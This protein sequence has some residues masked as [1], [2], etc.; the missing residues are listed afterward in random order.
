[1]LVYYLCTQPM[2]KSKSSAVGGP[3]V[4]KR[5]KSFLPWNRSKYIAHAEFLGETQ[6]EFFC[7]I[8]IITAHPSITVRINA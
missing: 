6:L 5:R 1:M 8:A 7:P 4:E 2:K 3:G